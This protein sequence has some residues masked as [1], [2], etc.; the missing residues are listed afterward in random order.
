LCGFGGPKHPLQKPHPDHWL[1]RGPSKLITIIVS[2]FIAIVS[3]VPLWA[4]DPMRSS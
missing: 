4:Y 2:V 3:R 1:A